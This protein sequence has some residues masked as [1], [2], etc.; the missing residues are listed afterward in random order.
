MKYTIKG[1]APFHLQIVSR[2][3]NKIFFKNI[4]ARKV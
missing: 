1:H 3:M 4:K 2:E